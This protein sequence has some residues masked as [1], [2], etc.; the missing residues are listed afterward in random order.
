[1]TPPLVSVLMPC[2]NVEPWIED[3]IASVRAQHYPH[4]ELVVVDDGSTDN[5]FHR[6]VNYADRN[7]RLEHQG[8]AKT[9]NFAASQAKGD[10][11]M[12]MGGEDHIPSGFMGEAVAV[13]RGTPGA[14]VACPT[15][16]T[17]T[18]DRFASGNS[19]RPKFDLDRLHLE[20]CIPGP[21]VF[22]RALFDAVPWPAGFEDTG[23]EDWSHWVLIHRAGL[24]RPVRMNAPYY[25]RQ[26]EGGLSNNMAKN[27]PAIRA[28]IL[29]LHETGT[30]V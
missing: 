8:I 11:L 21:S 28:K 5:T 4:I 24:L 27:M 14:T 7:F 30:L 10:L 9:L 12:F 2:Y 16:T 3:T 15:V 19:W 1:M 29:K 22:R 20:N 6:A 25:H 18:D 23:C 17:F 26:R 13:L